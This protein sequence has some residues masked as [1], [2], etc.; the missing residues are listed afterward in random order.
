MLSDLAGRKILLTGAGGF[1]GSHLA[2]ALSHM[3]ADLHVVLRPE[4]NRKRLESLGVYPKVLSADLTDEVQV[5]RYVAQVKPELVFHLAACREEDDWKALVEMNVS[6]PMALLSA[7]D[8]AEFRRMVTL[9]SSLEFVATLD[10]CAPSAFAASRMAGAVLIRQRAQ[11]L[12]VPL[13][14]LRVGYV[15]GPL[16]K[17]D[18][19]I[20]TAIRSA[21]NGDPMSVAPDQFRRQYVHVS[22]VVRACLLAATTSQPDYAR[23]DIASY[24]EWSPNQIIDLVGEIMKAPIQASVDEASA[25][26]WDRERWSANPAT[27]ERLFGWTPEIDLR[28]GLNGLV[29]GEDANSTM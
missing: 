18:K 11:D 13:T 15:Y 24:D 26:A 10:E 12:G 27:A 16:Q 7:C 6:A 23:A 21:R 5:A 20:P 4:T 28:Q 8:H 22:D 17:P 14:H 3:E 19:L 25:R 1:I 9:G 2:A 29:D